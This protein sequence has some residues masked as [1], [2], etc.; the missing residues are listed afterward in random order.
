MIRLIVD[1]TFGIP[2]EYINKHNIKM[3]NLKMILDG[4]ATDEGF[5]KDWASFYEK[6][7]KSKN[8][9]TTSQP[10]PQD[11]MDAID[12][13]YVEDK[14]AEIIILTISNALSGTINSATIAANSYEGKKI[15]AIDSRQA[16]TCGRIMVEE[17]VEKI[18][19]GAS[20]D[21]VVKFIEELSPRL[22]IQFVPESMDALK[23]GGRVSSVTATIASIL[24]IKPVLCFADGKISVLKKA[25]GLGNAIASM[26]ANIP[27]KLKKIY[28]CYIYDK[29]LIPSILQ[30]IKT[31]LNIEPKAV[32]LE[33]VFGVHVGIGSVGIATLSE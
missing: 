32:C 1:S 31:A 21:E 23:R 24:K 33:P 13:V 28:V 10:S 15:K 12:S 2:E 25:L 9:P 30:K 3:V 19:E 18:E 29:S 5:E 16:T 22:K 8:F 6:M 27:K 11:F 17:V 14:D 26:I 7:K 4:E 20:F